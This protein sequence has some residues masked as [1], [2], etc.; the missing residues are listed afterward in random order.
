MCVNW[1]EDNFLFFSYSILNYFTSDS[2]E[3][4]ENFGTLN[5]IF[6]ICLFEEYKLVILQYINEENR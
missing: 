1:E 4:F 5:V 3:F 6:S 2:V